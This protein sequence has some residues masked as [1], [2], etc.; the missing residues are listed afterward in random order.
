MRAAGE[1]ARAEAAEQWATEEA[2][3]A[4]ESGE[5]RER[6]AQ[7]GWRERRRILRELRAARVA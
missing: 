1:T 3:A 7:A 6:L 4:A 5:W 2:Q